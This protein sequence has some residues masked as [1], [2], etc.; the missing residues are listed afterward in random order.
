[1]F[2]RVFCRWIDTNA[3]ANRGYPIPLGRRGGLSRPCPAPD[4]T[5][6][7]HQTMSKSDN[8]LRDVALHVSL[9][10]LTTVHRYGPTILGTTLVLLIAGV[11]PVAAQAGGSV[12]S[13]LCGTPIA[14]TINRVVPLAIAVLM[15][16]G[17]VLAYLL[18]A[19]SGLA[20]S[21]DQVRFYKNWRNRAGMSAVTAP[22]VGYLLEMVLGFTGVGMAGC[23]HLVPFFG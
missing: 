8:S 18:H 17:L 22:L 1:M 10:G 9:P 20:K 6:H 4:W 5:T 14:Q 11:A 16:V 19:G 7:P 3:N 2:R 13:Q 21:T 12:G 15:T 23:I